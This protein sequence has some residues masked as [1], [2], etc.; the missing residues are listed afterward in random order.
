MDCALDIKIVTGNCVDFIANF[1][2]RFLR[3]TRGIVYLEK[4][5]LGGG[6]APLRTL[7]TL[8]VGT[9]LNAS[10]QILD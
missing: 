6:E 5:T 4:G 7:G 9:K 2:L 3:G 1:L 8:S 10:L